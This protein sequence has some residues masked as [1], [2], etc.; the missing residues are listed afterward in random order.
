MADERRHD[1]ARES[2]EAGGHA[3]V[4]Q[5]SG[6]GRPGPSGDAAARRMAHAGATQHLGSFS[7]ESPPGHALG[8]SKH[9]LK[10][11]DSIAFEV[12]GNQI[13]N[14]AGFTLDPA[15]GPVTMTSTKVKSMHRGQLGDSNTYRFTFTMSSS[16]QA[17][18][19]VTAQSEADYQSRND[20]GWSFNF[21]I[22]CA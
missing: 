9:S 4:M 11:G 18:Q 15:N 3:D 14:V 6:P 16:A 19:S 1:S 13:Y 12:A 5:E 21:T 8:G 2:S 10:P 7:Q 17:G 22:T 20:P